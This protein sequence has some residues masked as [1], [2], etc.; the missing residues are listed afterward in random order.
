MAAA[1]LLKSGA[2][3]AA[4][5]TGIAGPG[6]D[7]GIPAGTVWVATAVSAV[8]P[9]AVLYNFTGSRNEVREQAA[10]AVIRELINA[11]DRCG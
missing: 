9:L 5:V 6:S 7:S 1:A 3:I 8:E 2:S 11:L 4:A 10:I